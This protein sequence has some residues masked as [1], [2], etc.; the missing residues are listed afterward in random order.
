MNKLL[1][2]VVPVYNVEKYINKCLDSL[3]VPDK[4]MDSIEVIVVNDGTPDNSSFLAKQYEEKYP[5]TFHVI[6]KEN[7]GHGSAFNVGLQEAT[8]KYLR[9]LDSDDWFDTNNFVKLL[10]IL[11]DTDVDLVLNPFNYYWVERNEY[12][13][14]PIK[15]I[16]FGKVY[17]TN[18]F[19]FLHSGNRPNLTVFHS[20]TYKTELLKPNLPLFAEK[21]FYDDMVLRFAPILLSETFVAYDFPIY[22]YLYGRKD[23]TVTYEN[24]IKH[25]PDLNKVCKG[26]V[27]LIKNNPLSE[28]QRSIYIRNALSSIL[29][30]QV[31]TASRLRYKDS[32]L[33][34]NEI[35]QVMNDADGL[36]D[37]RIRYKVY[38]NLPFPL[39]YYSF[40][41]YDKLF[42]KD[43]IVG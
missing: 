21:V 14:I 17:K 37:K 26:I 34:L 38:K 13:L 29:Y 31:E 39:F 41:L 33:Y 12:E 5:N 6:D 23:Q 10:D 36:F 24:K 40:R 32:K 20:G 9:F 18:D 35:S 30:K 2:I 4:Y 15:S 28:G 3:I 25:F 1:T 42:Y 11:N 8:G 43:T 16:E 19:D 22:N 27:S 7:G